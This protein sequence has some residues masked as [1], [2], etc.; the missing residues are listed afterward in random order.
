MDG[1]VQD[2]NGEWMFAGAEISLVT[3]AQRQSCE[4]E[5]GEDGGEKGRGHIHSGRLR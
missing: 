4:S 5:I 2:S 3:L 1:R